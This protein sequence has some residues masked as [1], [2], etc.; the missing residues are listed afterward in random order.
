MQHDK[1][2]FLEKSYT[3]CH[4]GTSLRPFSEKLKF[5]IPPDHLSKSYTVC[6]YCMP[7]WGLSL[8]FTSHYPFLKNKK[9]SGTSLPA[10]F[11]V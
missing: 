1:Q 5:S 9:R 3:E 7:S 2:I 6:F 10:T 8:A 11:F 4:G